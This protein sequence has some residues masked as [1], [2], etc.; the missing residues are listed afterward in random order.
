[1][2]MATEALSQS[3]CLHPIGA[4]RVQLLVLVCSKCGQPS[5]DLMEAQANTKSN[6]WRLLIRFYAK[7]DEGGLEPVR[8]FFGFGE[9][10][11]GTCGGTAAKQLAPSPTEL[12]RPQPPTTKR[13]PALKLPTRSKTSSLSQAL[14]LSTVAP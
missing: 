13:S 10:S 3:A 1:M 14:A 6:Y 8:A 4:Q 9:G 5:V 7:R 2:Q 12:D 11:S